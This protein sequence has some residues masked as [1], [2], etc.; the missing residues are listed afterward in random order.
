MASA[1]ADTSA[2]PTASV[3]RSSAA[4]RKERAVV[5]Y[6]P[7][8]AGATRLLRSARV[9]EQAVEIRLRACDLSCRPKCL[10]QWARRRGEPPELWLTYHHR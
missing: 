6:F 1:A 10:D 2:R 5:R 4:F 8:L 7:A 9:I 3:A